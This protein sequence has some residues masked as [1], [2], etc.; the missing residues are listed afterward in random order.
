MPLNRLP[1]V[2][3]AHV[4]VPPTREKDPLSAQYYRYPVVFPN[5]FWILKESLVP[6]NDIVTSNDLPPP[7]YKNDD[8]NVYRV[9]I[10][11]IFEGNLTT[12]PINGTICR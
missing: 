1:P 6:V 7:P 9:T 2:V 10:H 4:N 5:N 8:T 11:K 12:K 3:Y